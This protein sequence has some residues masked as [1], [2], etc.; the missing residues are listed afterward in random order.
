MLRIFVVFLTVAIALTISVNGIATAAGSVTHEIHCLEHHGLEH[1]HEAGFGT[2][3]QTSGDVEAAD[4]EHEHDSCMFH[5]CSA[6]FTESLER[7]APFHN[8]IADL[9]DT[10]SRLR[11]VERVENL[12]R[13]PNT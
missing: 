5:A 3:L 11:V 7:P 10:A 4:K 2:D 9:H 13:P 12:H 6:V 1:E 8:V